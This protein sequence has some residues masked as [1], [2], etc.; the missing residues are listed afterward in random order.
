[1]SAKD[2]L[3]VFEGLGRPRILVLGDLMLDRYTWGDAERVSQEAPVIVLRA[4]RRESRP[5]GAANVANML[6]GLEAVVTT[7][8]VVG[9]DP[10]AAELIQLLHQAGIRCDPVHVDST[11]PTSVKERFVGRAA[12]RHPSQILRVDHES[13]QPLESGV[14]DALVER[15]VAEVP[16]HDALLISDYGKGVC[17]ERVLQ[18]AITAARRA[19]VPVM[20]DPSRGTPMSHYRGA[21]LV[22]PN[23]VETELATGHKI[24]SADDALAAGRQL[25][26]DVAIDL[27]LV[28]LDRDG[29]VLVRQDGRGETFSTHARAVYDI[30][31]AGDMVMAMVG[32][33][34][35]AKL[36]VADAVRLG[37][38]AAGLEVERTGVAVIYRQ[39]ILAELAASDGGIARKIATRQQA[40]ELAAEYRRRGQSVVFTNGCFDL[41]HVGHVKILAEA[42]AQGDALFVG[43]NSDASVTR[44]KG[45][46]R[47][48]IGEMDR[49]ALL[50]ALASVQHVVIFEEDTPLALIE[51]IRPD[52]LVKG[53]TYSAETIVGSDFVMSYGGRVHVTGMIEGMSTSN[54]LASAA[55]GETIRA[56]APK[57]PEVKPH[58]V[59]PTKPTRAK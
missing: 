25:C 4:D 5:G 54:V 56:L 19:G 1:M 55:R 11:R 28:T 16:R 24:G 17:T 49:A 39:E 10:A 33:C 53:G 38:A 50:A 12:N 31:G 26:R 22:K 58:E 59:K 23:R 35:A 20:I 46:G 43:L 27:V 21:T 40:A 29:M 45:P 2:L 3:H 13:H 52:V 18:A 15:L 37:N 9:D 57:P 44:L 34:L 7:S 32:L 8:G 47:P 6:A 36:D 30:T 41:L 51:A 14:E 48:V 42:A